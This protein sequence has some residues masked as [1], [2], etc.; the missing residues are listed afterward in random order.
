VQE[1]KLKRMCLFSAPCYANAS[2]KLISKPKIYPHGTEA[3]L[4]CEDGYSVT[5]IINGKMPVCFNGT[6]KPE[7]ARFPY[8]GEND[9]IKETIK[10]FFPKFS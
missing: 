9:K 5:G 3:D 10:N 8:C 1:V 2:D 6:W 4:K 7:Y